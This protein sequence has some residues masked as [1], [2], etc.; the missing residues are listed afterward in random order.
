MGDGKGG[1]LR[2]FEPP[3][4]QVDL[5][6]P[7]TFDPET[8]TAAEAQWEASSRHASAKRDARDKQLRARKRKIIVTSVA[9]VIVVAA[10]IPL[11]RAVMREAA[12]AE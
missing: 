3:D 2:E 12:I 1:G 8:R 5:Q 9:A 4:D 10:A 11:T 7:G 6:A